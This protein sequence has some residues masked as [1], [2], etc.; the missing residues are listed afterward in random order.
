MNI[1][2]QRDT[3]PPR[4]V[5]EDSDDNL[6][7]S[8]IKEAAQTFDA[9]VKTSFHKQIPTP[10]YATVKSKPRRKALNYIGQKITK[11]LFNETKQ[12][13]NKEKQLK[14]NN[15]K[16]KD[17]TLLK[18]KRK[19]KKCNNKE[20]SRKKAGNDETKAKRKKCNSK[21][22][23]TSKQDFHNEAWYC[24]ACDVERIADMRQCGKC[25]SWYHEDCVGLTREDVELFVCPEC[26]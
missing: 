16:I 11:D 7:F 21:P 1:S 9:N 12:N 15:I 3:T 4:E 13:K 14:E 25:S 23:K 20:E 6:P 10:N 2:R 19:L 8:Q 17:K 26:T 18:N 24:L 5:S 22:E